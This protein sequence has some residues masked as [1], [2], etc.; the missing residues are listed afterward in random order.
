VAE[1]VRAESD[2]LLGPFGPDSASSS[3]TMAFTLIAD[4]SEELFVSV[5]G[6]AEGF[7]TVTPAPIPVPPAIALLI[8]ALGGLGAL[9]G[10]RRS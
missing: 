4:P 8:T 7:A 10:L 5:G 1:E 6:F 9:R 3:G 2:A